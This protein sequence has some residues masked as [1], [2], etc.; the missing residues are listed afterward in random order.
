MCPFPYATKRGSWPRARQ[1][2]TAIFRSADCSGVYTAWRR[3]TDTGIFG[4]GLKPLPL[5]HRGRVCWWWPAT[6]KSADKTEVVLWDSWGV[7]SVALH[8][9]QASQ[10]PSRYR[11]PTT[12]EDKTQAPRQA[13]I[14]APLDDPGERAASALWVDITWS[15]SPASGVS[16]RGRGISCPL[17]ASTNNPDWESGCSSTALAPEE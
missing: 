9:G 10:R 1:T 3:Q 14:S 13:F 11:L 6:T 8:F 7:P 15:R 4:Y 16:P 5:P 12:P 2:K 17:Q